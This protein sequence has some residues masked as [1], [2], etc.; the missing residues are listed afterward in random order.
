MANSA[1][2]ASDSKVGS[3]KAKGK[4]MKLPETTIRRIDKSKR[5]FKDKSSNDIC[6][7][8]IDEYNNEN[9]ASYDESKPDHQEANLSGESRKQDKHSK[10]N[11]KNHA[12]YEKVSLL[13]KLRDQASMEI[14]VFRQKKTR[15]PAIEYLLDSQENET[16]TEFSYI[17]FIFPKCSDAKNNKETMDNKDTIETKGNTETSS[18]SRGNI[19]CLTYG[20]AYHVIHGFEDTK[21]P[22]DVSKYAVKKEIRKFDVRNLRGTCYEVDR[23]YRNPLIPDRLEVKGVVKNLQGRVGSPLLERFK[24]LEV[25][26]EKGA[27]IEVSRKGVRFM[28]DLTVEKM[29]ELIKELDDDK[30]KKEHGGCDILDYVCEVEN[31]KTIDMLEEKMF[32]KILKFVIEGL[33]GNATDNNDGQSDPHRYDVMYKDSEL[34]M[35]GKDFK[36][37]LPYQKKVDVCNELGSFDDV[38]RALRI[39]LKVALLEKLK[40][41]FTSNEGTAKRK[42]TFVECLHGTYDKATY[43]IKSGK[44]EKEGGENIENDCQQLLKE[45]LVAEILKD[46]TKDSVSNWLQFHFF[47]KRRKLTKFSFGVRE[48]IKNN[49]ASYSD[50]LKT[51]KSHLVKK[52]RITFRANQKSKED[53]ILNYFHGEVVL[54]DKKDE[55]KIYHKVDGRWFEIEEQYNELLKQSFQKLLSRKFKDGKRDDIHLPKVW[56]IGEGED[57]YN[58]LYNDETGFYVADK[59]TP[60]GIELCDIMKLS[61]DAIY[62]YHVKEGFG[63]S[64]RDACSQIRN[65]ASQLRGAQKHYLEEFYRIAIGYKGKGKVQYRRNLKNELIN[66]GKDRFLELFQNN[67]VVFVYAFANKIVQR[68]DGSWPE[69]K[70]LS[71]F[72]DKNV[73][74]FSRSTIARN[75]LHDTNVHLDGL[76]FDFALCQISRFEEESGKGSE[77]AEKNGKEKEKEGKSVKKEEKEECQGRRREMIQGRDRGKGK[78]KRQGKGK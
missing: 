7:A 66:L 29:C 45:Q 70:M 40:L 53:L 60:L 49:A 38:I 72:K 15:K 4:E 21:F 46:M 54:D 50:A 14:L 62:L 33:S 44:F 17:F 27:R 1:R 34:H 58:Q 8:I 75:E 35:K 56:P 5:D 19:Y 42:P 30:V 25:G 78:E 9:A 28:K 47:Y 48:T 65:S 36:L 11:I 23:F 22:R 16:C 52:L 41:T 71:E 3:S 43:I 6:Q 20:G 69:D 64:T 12:K 37:F 67:K 74:N 76:E 31:P 39:V 10:V 57:Y 32:D 59:I 68:K 61:A 55:S 51:L 26:T 63:Q 18:T 2:K 24:V 13:Q 73:E 77:K